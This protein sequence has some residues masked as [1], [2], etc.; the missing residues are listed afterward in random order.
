MLKPISFPK[1]TFLENWLVQLTASLDDAD[2]SKVYLYEV[3]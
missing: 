2:E 1:E 3:P